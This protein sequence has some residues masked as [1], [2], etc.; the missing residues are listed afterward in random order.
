[1]L[2]FEMHIMD[3]PQS[4]KDPAESLGLVPRII[5]FSMLLTVLGNFMLVVVPETPTFKAM[6]PSDASP[7]LAHFIMFAVTVI[8]VGFFTGKF[9]NALLAPLLV[10]IDVAE[11]A[12]TGDLNV[13]L[14]QPTDGEPGRLVR[15]ISVMIRRLRSSVNRMERLAYIDPVTQLPNRNH[16]KN[17]AIE[18]IQQAARDNTELAV[19]FLDMDRFKMVNDT[20][21]H[22][23]GDRLLQMFAERLRT[24]LDVAVDFQLPTETT[25]RQNYNAAAKIFAARIGGDE[26]TILMPKTGRLT[27]VAKATQRILKAMEDPFDFAGESVVMSVSIGIA[28]Y[29]SDGTDYETLLRNADI[30]M[31]YAKDLG[32]KTYQF[33]SE[34]MDQQ[35]AER[36][37]IE[38][39]LRE[40]IKSEAFEVFYQPQ[41][42][43]NTHAIIGAEALVRWH[44][45]VAGLMAPASF[46]KI[47]EDYGLIIDIGAFVLRQAVKQAAIW[48]QRGSPLRVSVNVSPM[49][50]LRADFLTLLR[51]VLETY[52]LQPW[53][54][55]LELTETLAMKDTMEIRQR[56]DD[57]RALG[58]SMAIDDFGTGYSNLGLLKRLRFDRL[59]IDRS[60]I[61]GI[62]IQEE[63]RMIVST[64]LAMAQT[65]GYEVVAEG[66]ETARQAEILRAA[67][68]EILQGYLFSKPKPVAEFDTYWKNYLQTTSKTP[69]PL[70]LISEA[71]S[72]GAAPTDAIWP[73]QIAAMN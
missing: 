4:R 39:Q 53:L 45:P 70:H 58:V 8:G 69:A 10:L 5:A 52:Q 16:F 24:V 30:A 18:A 13:V 26:F 73:K 1:M 65:F 21:G 23:Q 17:L 66:V 61:A 19:L 71:D 22:A 3:K 50:L 32:R 9:S 64:M 38:G 15:A 48:A 51:D 37:V 11:Q 28:C 33:Y 31:L 12:A 7:L 55:E 25:S 29:P 36:L 47:A 35:S 20:L 2:M 6:L 57:I 44:H 56:F 41:V 59:K 68:C 72:G 43:A 54:L 42:S 46:I 27:D 40:A 34:S 49:Q 67:G 60:F 14:P 62:E 63:A